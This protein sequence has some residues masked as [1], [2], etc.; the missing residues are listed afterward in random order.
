MIGVHI[1]P[2]DHPRPR[3]LC[4]KREH[5]GGGQ[6]QEIVTFEQFVQGAIPLAAAD[7]GLIDIGR[8]QAQA[9]LDFPLGFG[10]ELFALARV[11][12]QR[13]ETAVHQ[14]VT[15]HQPSLPQAFHGE[16][17]LTGFDLAA[18]ARKVLQRRLA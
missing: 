17:R 9:T 3:G 15:V 4:I 11:G 2:A 10:L 16:I 14:P 13:A 8:S 5:L 12:I 7:R 18:Q 1:L 6:Q